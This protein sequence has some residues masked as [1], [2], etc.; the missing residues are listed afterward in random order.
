[1]ARIARDAS[2]NVRF[3]AKVAQV[4]TNNT[5]IVSA[6]SAQRDRNVPD[7]PHGGVDGG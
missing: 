3:V 2:R 5:K 1:M 7:G 4:V 6:L